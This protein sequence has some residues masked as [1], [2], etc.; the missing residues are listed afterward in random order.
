MRFL[1]EMTKALKK[2]ARYAQKNYASGGGC[3]DLN[4]RQNLLACFFPSGRLK[5]SPLSARAT[6]LVSSTDVKEEPAVM[7]M[8]CATG[9]ASSP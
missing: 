9:R 5:P 7:L 8:C 4:R 3:A 6:R 2:F 1:T